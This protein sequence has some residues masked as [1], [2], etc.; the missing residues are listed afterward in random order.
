[1]NRN[2]ILDYDRSLPVKL[3]RPEDLTKLSFVED[4]D[5]QAP[6]LP[7]KIDLNSTTI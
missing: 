4:D 5:T 7:A 2:R 3:V 6:P 1:M